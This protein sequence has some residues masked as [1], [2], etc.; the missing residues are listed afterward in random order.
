MTEPVGTTA[1]VVTLLDRAWASFRW[2]RRLRPWQSM[3]SLPY[4]MRPP[5]HGLELLPLYFDISLGGQIPTISIHSNAINYTRKPIT[6]I[7]VIVSHIGLPGGPTLDNVLLSAEYELAPHTSMLITCRR[8]LMDS[9][10][11][12]ITTSTSRTARGASVSLSGRGRSG[13]SEIGYGPVHN[14]SIVGLYNGFP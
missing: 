3:G 13:R 12:A 1:A 14:E 11:R 5:H 10:A 2:V 6:L 4:A 9:E 7:A 8:N